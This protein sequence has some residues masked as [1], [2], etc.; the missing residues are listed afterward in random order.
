MG[1]LRYSP[2]PRAPAVASLGAD[3]VAGLT[4]QV[5]SLRYPLKTYQLKPFVAA[6]SLTNITLE[7]RWALQL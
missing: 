4:V 5:L 2:K 6:I 7:A 1:L 3:Y